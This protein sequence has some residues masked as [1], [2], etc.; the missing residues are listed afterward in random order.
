MQQVV[1]GIDIG[2]TGIKFGLVNQNGEILVTDK[3]KTKG[4]P[5]PEKLP[6]DL[7]KWSQQQCAEL[8]VHLTGVGIGTPNGNYYK[9]TIDFAPNLPWKGVIP[10]KAYFEKVFNL[11]VALT[12]DAKA[13]A[14]GEMFFGA[15]KGM[16]DFIFITLGTGLGSGIVV[17]GNIAYGFDSLAGEVGHTIV[18][19]NG[20]ECPCGRRGC[21]EQYVS[22]PG[23]VK[24]YY[25]ILR[26]KNLDDF[27]T[28]IGNMIDSVEL[29]KRANEGDDLAK[30]AFQITGEILG[31]A[32]SN[33]V[34]F[35]R[36][37]KIFLFGGLAQA[38][39]I[40]F[41]PTIKSFESYLLPIYKNKIPIIPSGL[42]ES[43]AAIL[44]S[45]SLIMKEI[46]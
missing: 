6:E 1:L 30:E 41:E 10:L 23:I 25:E 12:N 28:S 39:D 31:F 36:P 24:T 5:N 43:E 34:C 27:R 42:K 44:G 29:F 18:Y 7:F 32:L 40:L 38:G 20:R 13:A 37:E 16:K 45:A 17:N 33:A 3:V 8:D 11:P 4:Y 2:G 15:A 9:G 21:L 35:T 19:R 22:A 26:K 46:A 14:I